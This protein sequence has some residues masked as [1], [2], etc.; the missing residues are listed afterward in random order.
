MS[1]QS[2][3]IRRILGQQPVWP[4]KGPRLN[5]LDV[6]LTERCNNA[7]LH[8][9]I[10]LP[11]GDAQ[12][13]ARELGTPEWQEILREAAELG[14][15]AVRFTGGEPLLRDDFVE[16]YLFARKLGMKVLLFTNARRITPHLASLFERIPPLER[17]EI[18]VY[19]MHPQSYDAATCTPGAYAEFWRG[20]NLLLDHQVPFVV[21]GALLPPNKSEIVEFETWAAG[22][23]WMDKPPGFSMF[24]D[25]R[26]RRDSPARNRLISRLRLSPQEG[27]AVLARHEASYWK[28]MRQF[29]SRLSGPAGAALFTCG[30]GQAVSVD[31]YGKLQPC[32]L[33]RDPA[34]AYDLHKGSLLDGLEFFSHRLREIQIVNPVYLERCAACFLQGF[35]E[36]CPAK[37][38][39]EHG[40][41]DTPVEYLCEAAHALARHLGLL[42]DGEK[43]WEVRD[44]KERIN[45]FQS[46]IGEK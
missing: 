29:C 26:G 14:T 2:Y 35:C 36:Q 16:L 39:S 44:W 17:I 24:F 37:S 8:C 10:N 42:A 11:A 21:K 9:C 7:C 25:L 18:T 34:L 5:R 12:A 3:T 33:L 28:G 19:G 31:A 1:D 40:N 23:P 41:L 43:A 38:W 22:L 4:G 27:I 30:A 13:Q 46:E 45:I 6:E 32:L 15:L 20:V